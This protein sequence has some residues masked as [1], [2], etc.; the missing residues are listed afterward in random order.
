M[1]YRLVRVFGIADRSDIF[2]GPFLNLFVRSL[3]L[4]IL[5][6]VKMAKLP[7]CIREDCLASG[8]ESRVIVLDVIFALTNPQFTRLSRNSFQWISISHGATDRTRI[9]RSLSLSIPPEVSTAIVLTL[10]FSLSFT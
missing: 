6:R 8:V 5:C 10:T 9:R 1:R 2:S 7:F 3:F 4:R